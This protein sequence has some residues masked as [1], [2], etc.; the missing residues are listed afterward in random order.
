MMLNL[1]R[2]RSREQISQWDASRGTDASSQIGT[3]PTLSRP[4]G[5]GVLTRDT[6]SRRQV[7]RFR[8]AM[9]FE[10]VGQCHTREYT[11]SKRICHLLLTLAPAISILI[12]SS[13]GDSITW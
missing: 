10:Q 7:L 1:R 9:G 3:E 11:P 13:F 5:I 4:E 6:R 8:D 2:G 12:L